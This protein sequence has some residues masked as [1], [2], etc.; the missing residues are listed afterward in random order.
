[1]PEG[2]P[3]SAFPALPSLDGMDEWCLWDLWFLF[4][5]IPEPLEEHSTAFRE[6]SAQMLSGTK[7]PLP[8]WAQLLW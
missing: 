6:E 5:M 8:F 3:R 1:M 4:P 7:T 2:P